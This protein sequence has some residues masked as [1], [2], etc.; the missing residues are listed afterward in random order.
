M[1]LTH[2]SAPSG[3]G[4]L[5]S[6]TEEPGSLRSSLNNCTDTGLPTSELLVNMRKTLSY[7][8]KPLPFDLCYLPQNT[9]FIRT[10]NINTLHTD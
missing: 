10:G 4:C 3:P 9:T 5:A 1:Q 2:L 8:V 7:L 6:K